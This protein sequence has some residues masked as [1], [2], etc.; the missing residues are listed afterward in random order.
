MLIKH[1]SDSISSQVAG[2]IGMNDSSGTGGVGIA[3]ECHIGCTVK[4]CN[5]HQSYRIFLLMGYFHG[6]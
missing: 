2:I 1:A 3:P 5:T 4:I 6:I